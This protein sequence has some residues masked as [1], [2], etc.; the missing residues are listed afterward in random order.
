MIS[1]IHRLTV[2]D[3]I[4][5]LHSSAEGLS[6][7]EAERRLRE[8]GPNRVEELARAPLAL[9]LAKEVTHLFSLI[10]WLAAGLAFFAGWGAPGQGMAR[11]GYAII[12]IDRNL[13]FLTTGS[14]YMTQMIP[15]LIVAPLYIRG[16]REFG[17]GRDA[18]SHG[19]WLC[20]GGIFAGGDGVPA[21]VLARCC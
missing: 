5:S 1:Q 19:V 11:L 15:V 9:R 14:N 2:A 8:F 10:L 12:A 20:A 3:A 7:S 6:H 13:G 16:E 4:A 18:G 17:R 21:A